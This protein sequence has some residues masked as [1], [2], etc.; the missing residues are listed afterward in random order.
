MQKIKFFLSM[1]KSICIVKCILE[2]SIFNLSIL[3]LTKTVDAW[4]LGI[5]RSRILG[6]SS[7]FTFCIVKFE[8]WY[9]SMHTSCIHIINASDSNTQEI[10]REITGK[11][12]TVEDLAAALTFPAF[13]I[14]SWELFEFLVGSQSIIISIVRC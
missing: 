6:R 7:E 5:C 4:E 2:T 1:P 8:I 14:D 10:L 9:G 3:F 13:Y 11:I 12:A